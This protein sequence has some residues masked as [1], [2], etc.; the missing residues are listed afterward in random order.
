MWVQP[1]I[2]PR[3]LGS[4]FQSANPSLLVDHLLLP[5][6]RRDF[7]IRGPRR[8]CLHKGGN[9]GF[10]LARWAH[11]LDFENQRLLAQVPSDKEASLEEEVAKL[12]DEKAKL[13]AEWVDA[14]QIAGSLLTAKRRL[15]D[16]CLG[17]R[18]KFEDATA[19]NQKLGEES[20]NFDIQITQLSATRDAALE[21]TKLARQEAEDLQKEKEVLK[22]AAARHK[23]DIWAAVEN[24]K[25]STELWERFE[26]ASCVAVEDFKASPEFEAALLAIVERF[27]ASPEFNDALGTNAAFGA[28]SFVKRCKEKYPELRSDFPE[29]QKDYESSWFADLDLDASSS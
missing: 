3:S 18:K 14:Q 2:L 1:Y 29:F 9:A 4:L 27:K 13:E 8:D 10:D 5:L 25:V 7:Q 28:F 11:N 12:N 16:D 20:S 24:Y 19:E 23:K 17:L 26:A 21:E 15:L 22:N 6:R